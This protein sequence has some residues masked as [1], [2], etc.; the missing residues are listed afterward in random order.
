[1]TNLFYIM[2]K[3]ATGKDTIYK[4]I[5]ENIDINEQVPYTTRP[6]RT[7]EKDGVDYHFITDEMLEEYRIKNKI[8]EKRTYNTAHGLWTYA[9]IADKQLM[10][11]GNILTIGTLESYNQ[12][13]EYYANNEQ[14]KILPIYIEID[15]NERRE[16]ALKREKKQ[17]NPKFEEMER[18]LKADNIDF[19]KEKLEK[20]GITK[21]E[22]FENYDLDECVNKI[23]NYIK[24][25]TIVNY[26]N[27][28][29]K[30]TV[31]YEEFEEER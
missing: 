7:G 28:I 30:K 22:T 14:T 31:N 23:T 4:K 1:M 10:E 17:E 6:I 15:E 9:T 11:E 20:S 21:K 8:I 18:R 13:R 12:I 19:S 29:R 27:N 26:K 16:R 24:T 2:G 3:S 5:K 25:K